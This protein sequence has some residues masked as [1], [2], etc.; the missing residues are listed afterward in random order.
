MTIALVGYKIDLNNSIFLEKKTIRSCEHTNDNSA[1]FCS[2]CGIKIKVE[3]R[4]V[5]NDVYGQV[6]E[7]SDLLP[8][9]YVFSFNGNNLYFVGYGIQIDRDEFG[10]LDIPADIDK[11]KQTIKS[12]MPEKVCSILNDI[13]FGVWIS[14]L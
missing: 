13:N 10:K 4:R 11:V 5:E 12:L 2:T 1:K 6:L 14:N 3:T 7:S 9:D 8:D